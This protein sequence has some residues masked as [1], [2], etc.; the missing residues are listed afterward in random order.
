MVQ[1]I[2]QMRNKLRINCSPVQIPIGLEHEH[3]GLVDLLT[4]KAFHFQ[5]AFGE[6][7]KEVGLP[8]LL[9][10]KNY[11]TLAGSNPKAYSRRNR[12]WRSILSMRG[13]LDISSPSLPS[14]YSHEGQAC[15]LLLV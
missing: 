5:G 10:L 8:I 6:I 13:F 1:V 14:L 11:S 3:V 4:M 7:L 9:L 12:V 2:E 15:K